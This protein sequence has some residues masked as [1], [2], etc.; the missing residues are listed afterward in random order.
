MSN[1]QCDKLQKLQSYVAKDVP[2]K[3]DYSH[4]TPCL[5]DL[6]WRPVKFRVDFEFE[7][8][9]FKCLNELALPNL[10]GNVEIFD[11]PKDL[12]YR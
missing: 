9:N 11:P 7:I 10:K 8:L 3:S 2:K 1:F 12:R 4:V 5:I 6:H